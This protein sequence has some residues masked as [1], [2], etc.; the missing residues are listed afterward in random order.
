MHA[1][2]ETQTQS[3][4]NLKEFPVEL[5]P[6]D[7]GYE[8]AELTLHELEIIRTARPNIS[9][10]KNGLETVCGASCETGAF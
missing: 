8:R 6:V 10:S 5:V 2:T 1:K 7:Y 4:F 9:A 3:L